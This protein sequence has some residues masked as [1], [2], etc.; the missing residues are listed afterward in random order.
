MSK[1]LHKASIRWLAGARLSILVAALGPACAL[2]QPASPPP[3]TQAPEPTAAQRLMG[4]INPKLAE[5]TDKVL[6]GD[7]WA[8]PG[9]SPRDRSLVTVSAL[10]AMNR[11]DQLRSHLQ[12]AKDNGV[13]EA[14][15][16]E[17]ITH[18]AF[19]AG[20]PS[21]VT[22]STVARDVFQKK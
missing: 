21:A 18:L 6:F 12:R 1:P 10:I 13:T 22:A 2:A 17:A 8:R 9:L 4:D 15:L 16:I 7:V 19:Y 5:L 3:P 14:E 20:W 11:P